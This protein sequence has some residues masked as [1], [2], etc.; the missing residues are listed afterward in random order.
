VSGYPVVIEGT[1][2]AALVIGGGAIG[3]RRALALLDAGVRV[4]VVAPDVAQ[5]LIDTAQQNTSLRIS[6]VEYS[7]DLITDE[8]LVIA[9]TNDG[10]TNAAVAADAR[11]RGRLVTVVSNAE[12]GNCTIPAVHRAG[13]VVVAISAGGV[14]NAAIR[15]RDAI[16]QIVDGRY[17]AAVAV[18]AT[19]RR[20]LLANGRQDRWQEAAQALIGAD[21]CRQVESGEFSARVAKW[22]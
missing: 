17:A 7:P 4:H 15:L 9:A 1:A 20:G 19:L 6:R 13:D 5:T 8:L 14:P 11:A 2:L 18:L 16:G 21:F 3:S 22:H 12:L 10:A